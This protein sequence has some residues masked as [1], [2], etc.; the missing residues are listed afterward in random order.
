MKKI[1]LIALALITLLALCVGCKK[2]AEEELIEH[3]SEDLDDIAQ[4][5]SY[6]AEEMS[7]VL[8]GMTDSAAEDVSDANNSNVISDEPTP[9]D[10]YERYMEVKNQ[11]LETLTA[12]IDEGVDFYLGAS[13]EL[14]VV[15]LIDFQTLD[16][17]FVTDDIAAAEAA[18]GMMGIDDMNLEYSDE[19]FTLSYT[20][21]NGEKCVRNGKYDAS[22]ESL[23]CTWTE[24]GAQTLMLEFTK[25]SAGYAAQYYITDE[26]G[27][28]IIQLLIDGENIV[29]GIGEDI[30]KPSSIY[31]A[32]PTNT[33][34]A[35][36][37]SSVYKLS[38]GMGT[39]KSLDGDYEF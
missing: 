20:G 23:T 36:D 5:V 33:T 8:K 13:F 22:T 35:D 16:L 19:D 1:L 4:D 10:S 15:A 2:S 37:C 21:D 30:P 14:L 3:I 9:C 11:G 34:F 28:S 6:A 17:S 12:S 31:K 24:D 29:L 39:Y 32:A 26:T 27:T 38:G 25:Y 7:D 18:A